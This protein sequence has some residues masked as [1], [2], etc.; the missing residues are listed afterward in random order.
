GFSDASALDFDASL[1]SSDLREIIRRERRVELALEGL[2][3]FDIR[4]WETA[5]TVLDGNP[6]GAQY[7]DPSIDNGYIRLDVRSFNPE[8]DYLW[9]VPQSQKDLNPNLGQNPGY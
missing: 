4:R 9:A 3:I 6:H 1:S 5:E 8:R 7:G 2:R